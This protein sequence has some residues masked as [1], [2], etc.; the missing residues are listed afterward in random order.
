MAIEDQ[1]SPFTVTM[2]LATLLLAYAYIKEELVF[3]F[4]WALSPSILVLS[5]EVYHLVKQH[6]G[7]KR[8][9]YI[10][11]YTLLACFLLAMSK[12]VKN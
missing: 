3:S 9:K 10:I 6:K 7:I 11:S 12:V 2:H 1:I 8:C 5:A 4:L